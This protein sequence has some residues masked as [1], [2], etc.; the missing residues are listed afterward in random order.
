MLRAESSLDADEARRLLDRYLGFCVRSGQHEAALDYLADSD[1]LHGDDPNLVRQWVKLAETLGKDAELCAGLD[2]LRARGFWGETEARVER[3]L[4]RRQG[5]DLLMQEAPETRSALG[6]LRRFGQSIG[7]AASGRRPSVLELVPAEVP[8][9]IGEAEVRQAASPARVQLSALLQQALDSSKTKV[10]LVGLDGAAE[11]M[12]WLG[13][14]DEAVLEA[15]RFAGAG[16]PHALNDLL[17]GTAWH[18]AGDLDGNLPRLAGYVAEQQTKMHLLQQGHQVEMPESPTQ[19]GYDLL[20]DGQPVQ[21]KHAASAAPIEEH[22]DRYPDIPVIA[23]AEHAAHYQDNPM[24]WTD[25]QRSYGDAYDALDGTLE[26]LHDAPFLT[27]APLHLLLAGMRHIDRA[28]SWR[29]YSER[30]AKDAGAGIAFTS[31]GFWLFSGVAG[32]ALGPVGVAVAG[33]LGAMIGS[34]L[35]DSMGK[36]WIGERIG[37]KNDAVAERLIELALWARDVAVPDKLDAAEREYTRVR[38][39]VA[40]PELQSLPVAITAFWRALA[41]AGVKQLTLFADRLDERLAGGEA[42]RIKAGWQVFQASGQIAHREMRE[43]VAVLQQQLGFL[44]A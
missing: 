35:G 17:E 38:R 4:V 3:K 12:L 5:D 28:D 21:V 15:V 11:Q 2:W 39:L 44:Q 36:A 1:V 18:A 42:D 37:E 7:L 41:E 6:A 43:R 13:Q 33:T 27:A 34:G 32:M 19:A 8:L 25:A 20:V 26:S 10:A 30:V 40:Q 24:V 9:L 29:D 22:L 14:L 23:N 31:G 16:S